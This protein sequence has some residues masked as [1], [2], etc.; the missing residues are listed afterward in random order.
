MYTVTEYLARSI[1]ASEG[2]RAKF[3]NWCHCTLIVSL[4]SLARYGARAILFLTISISFNKATHAY[5]QHTHSSR[6]RLVFVLFYLPFFYIPA[7]FLS[8]FLCV[9]LLFSSIFGPDC[10]SFRFTF[11]LFVCFTSVHDSIFVRRRPTVHLFWLDSWGRT[12][13]PTHDTVLGHVNRLCPHGRN[14]LLTT[15]RQNDVS[16]L[17]SLSCSFYSI[18]LDLTL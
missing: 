3:V 5:T 7:M 18:R 4:P 16:Y 8:F 17:L 10:F 14:T 15:R 1:A 6:T 12:D 13:I 11:H 2:N 9:W